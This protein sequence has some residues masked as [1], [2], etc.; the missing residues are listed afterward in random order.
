MYIHEYIT[1]R[2]S[3]P[4]DFVPSPFRWNRGH[5]IHSQPITHSLFEVSKSVP[6]LTGPTNKWESSLRI[7][8]WVRPTEW[9]NGSLSQCRETLYVH[10]PSVSKTR[11]VQIPIYVYI[12]RLY[13]TGICTIENEWNFQSRLWQNR[14]RPRT[15]AQSL[16]IRIVAYELSILSK[17]WSINFRLSVLHSCVFPVILNRFC[18]YISISIFLSNAKQI[19]KTTILHYRESI[20]R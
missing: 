2:Y 18:R 12:D 7:S 1:D 16:G 20:L 17:N 4:V 5:L 19:K 10:F 6:K 13:T 15:Q 11:L 3:S 14:R 9:V 8:L